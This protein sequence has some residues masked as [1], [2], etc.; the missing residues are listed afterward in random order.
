MKQLLLFAFLLVFFGGCV[1]SRAMVFETGTASWY[2]PNFHGKKT[3]NGET[4]NQ[5][6]LTA[7]HKTLPFN[8]VV[9]VHNLDNG[10]SVT[11]RINDRGPYADNRVIDLSFAAAQR[12]EMVNAG[13]A[14]V[15]IEV[16]R[17]DVPISEVHERELF[18]VQLASFTVKTQADSMASGIRG[19]Y[20]ERARVEGRTYYRVFVGRYSN[21]T[22]AEQKK[23]ELER[24]GH[25]GFVKQIQ[26]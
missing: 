11:V 21:R 4:Y 13:L 26:N 17:S 10:K 18:T 20:V 12:I 7:A 19:A 22:E 1:S 25:N 3:A 2:G 5:N 15:R 23:A 9:R 8:T 14:R 24:Q 6:D 16:L